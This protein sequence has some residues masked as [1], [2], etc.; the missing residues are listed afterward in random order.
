MNVSLRTLWPLR[1]REKSCEMREMEGE[2]GVTDPV[3]E[4]AG[5]KIKGNSFIIYQLPAAITGHDRALKTG[6]FD[7]NEMKCSWCLLSC[8][9]PVTSAASGDTRGRRAI[10]GRWLTDERWCLCVGQLKAQQWWESEINGMYQRRISLISCGIDP[11]WRQ[12][13][14]RL[15]DSLSLNV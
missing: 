6:I 13:S 10:G 1:L 8:A 11:L 4:A 12:H 14:V 15:I 3:W 9:W 7:G 5:P 2:V